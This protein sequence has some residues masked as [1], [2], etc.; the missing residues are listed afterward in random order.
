MFYTGLQ[1]DRDRGTAGTKEGS[2][3]I[4]RFGSKAKNVVVIVLFLHIINSK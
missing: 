2:S 4:G 1:K 3:S